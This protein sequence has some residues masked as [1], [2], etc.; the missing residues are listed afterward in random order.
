MNRDYSRSVIAGGRISEEQMVQGII[1]TIDASCD[2][3]KYDG[4][5][6]VRNYLFRSADQLKFS[7]ALR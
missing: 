5:P 4:I 2:S 1:N 7:E 6:S 3:S